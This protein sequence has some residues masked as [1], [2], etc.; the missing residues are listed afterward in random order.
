MVCI[1]SL[2]RIKELYCQS[3]TEPWFQSSRDRVNLLGAY[4]IA[5]DALDVFL[6]I[7]EEIQA[8]QDLVSVWSLQAFFRYT[9]FECSTNAITRI[10]PMRGGKEVPLSFDSK[11]CFMI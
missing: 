1:E 2:I 6:A 10:F 5:L 7:I 11:V 8:C 3:F 4:E 9:S